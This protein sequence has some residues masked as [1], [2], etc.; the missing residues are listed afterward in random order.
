MGNSAALMEYKI[1]EHKVTNASIE[2]PILDRML[3]GEKARVLY[4]DPP[5]GDGNMKYWTTL[6][7]KMTGKVYA[8]L[9]YQQLLDRI[10]DLAKKYVEGHVF[11]ETGRD[12]EGQVRKSMDDA[13]LR[14]IRVFH[15][16]YRS[17]A[18]ILPMIMLYGGTSARF[19]YDS[20]K[21][22]PTTEKGA[23]LVKKCLG[24]VAEEGQIVI[25]PCCGMGYTAKA[26]LHH[27]MRFRGNEFNTA[28]LQDTLDF[29]RKNTEGA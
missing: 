25:D 13:G 17:G 29:L 27:K 10:M 15:L 3:A 14:N 20:T 12:W 18:K 23:T 22:K 6:N 26:A 1:G 7:K 24:V 9:S 5:W 19:S 21:F 4:T 11:V 16:Q 2:D 8:P 28:R